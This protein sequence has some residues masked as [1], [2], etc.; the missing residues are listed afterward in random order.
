MY[1]PP[2]RVDYNTLY[3]A[4]LASVQEYAVLAVNDEKK[5]IDE[6]LKANDAFRDK[7]AQR[8]ERTIRE[9]Q[10]RI[11]EIDRLLQNLYED[12]ISQETTADIFKR[13]SQKYSE[14]QSKLILEV[15]QL[16]S[17][18]DECRRVEKD[19]SGWIS[20]IKEC[21]TINDLTRS[22]V[23][24]LIDRIDVSEIYSVDGEKNLDISISYKLGQS[25]LSRQRQEQQKEKELA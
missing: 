21:L 24:E 20:R 10:N 4:V 1:V 17:E 13:M 22:I 3:Q 8:Y 7:N 14:E 23:V 12:K 25:N 19:M 11:K 15:E 6:I 9:S 2:H 5:L 18:L 16:E